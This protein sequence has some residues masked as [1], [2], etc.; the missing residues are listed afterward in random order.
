MSL[1]GVVGRIYKIKIRSH[2]YE[3]S[4]D[5]NS[6][7]VAL[8]SLPSKPSNAPT[9]DPTITNQEKIGVVITLFDSTNNGGSQITNYMIE[10]DDG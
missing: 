6:L 4:V 8:A 3:G 9:S 7:S 2:N 1:S 5:S 10:Y